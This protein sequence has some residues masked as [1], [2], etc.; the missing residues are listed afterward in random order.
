MKVLKQIK[1]QEVPNWRGLKPEYVAL[2]E[3]VKTLS[4]GMSLPVECTD[5]RE[6]QALQFTI[7]SQQNKKDG[8]LALASIKCSVVRRKNVVY[9]SIAKNGEVK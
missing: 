4:D 6:A 2:F 9:I 8:L 5:I 1:A 3:K 7:F